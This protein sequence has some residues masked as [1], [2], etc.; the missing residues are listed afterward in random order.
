MS[1]TRSSAATRGASL[2]IGSPCLVCGGRYEAS[3]LPGLLRCSFCRFV[4]ANMSLPHAELEKLYTARYFAGEE[5]RDYMAE[6]PLLE[7]SFRRRLDKLL[8]YVPDAS[9]KRLVE[10]GSAYG[11]FLQMARDRFRSVEGHEISHDAAAHATAVFRLPVTVGDF[12]DHQMSGDIDVLCLWDTIEHLQAPHRYLE[13]A[14]AHMPSGSAIAVTTG[15]IESIVA[16]MRG[17]KWR[18]IHPPTHLH[19]FSKQTLA[20]LL[21]N[22]GF[23]VR[24][25]GYD[26]VYRS[27]DTAAY[28]IL[29]IKHQRPGIYRFLKKGGLLKGT[30]YLNLYD[31]LF[32]IAVKA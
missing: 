25:A 26:G 10:I 6:R 31:I 30:G 7:R 27:L 8:S 20:R 3:A 4:T 15:D 21:A 14:A 12:L 11:F 18:Q 5:Y 23:T 13:K 22:Y 29:N 19:Y 32:M 16:R 9:G 17:A 2:M 24:Y 1:S 28:T